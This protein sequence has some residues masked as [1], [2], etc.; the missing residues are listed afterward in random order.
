MKRVLFALVVA[1]AAVACSLNPQPFP[2]DNPDAAQGLTDASKT[3]DGSTF[4][5][6]TGAVPDAES[7]SE[8]VPDGDGG[9]GG[10][11]TDALIDAPIDAPLDALDD[12]TIVDSASD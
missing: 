9:D 1:A 3:N 2:P 8:P 5:D 6:A 11:A 10:D 7:D 4:G 12:V